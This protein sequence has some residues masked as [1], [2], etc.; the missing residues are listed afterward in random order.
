MKI[1]G[2]GLT[3]KSTLK[4]QSMLTMLTGLLGRN[5]SYKRIYIALMLTS[6]TSHFASESGWPE[7]AVELC[8]VADLA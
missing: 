7:E 8:N 4:L 3:P 5:C 1:Y 2:K 6:I